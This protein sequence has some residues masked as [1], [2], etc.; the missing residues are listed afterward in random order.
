MYFEGIFFAVI[1]FGTV[2]LCQPII[3]QAEFHFTYRIWPALLGIG[4]L[5]FLLALFTCFLW[6]SMILC[7]AALCFG[8]GA[9]RLQNHFHGR[10][11]PKCRRRK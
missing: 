2:L 8:C 11:P 7:I 5:L 9:F 10:R 3:E 6:L 4:I 1:S